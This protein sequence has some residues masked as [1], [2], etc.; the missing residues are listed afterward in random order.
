MA[1]SFH[2]VRSRRLEYER[3]VSQEICREHDDKA[4]AQL[5]DLL[6]AEGDEIELTRAQPSSSKQALYPEVH[7]SQSSF[8]RMI[9]P[10]SSQHLP[11]STVLAGVKSGQLHQGRFNA[12]QYNYSEVRAVES[13]FPE[14][15]HSPGSVGGKRKHQ[16]S[17]ARGR[18][19]N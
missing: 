1:S 17:G 16:P 5:L 15:L 18:G 19:G 6:S 3:F 8:I 2:P 14:F 12:R 10:D 13:H 9:D 11:L 4:A 7:S